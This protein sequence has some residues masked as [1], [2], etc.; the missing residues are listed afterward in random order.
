M[1]D[2]KVEQK[3]KEPQTNMWKD[4]L[5][6][7]MSKKELEDANIFIFGDQLT[8]KK[9]LIRVINKD[10]ISRN[11][12]E[13]KRY[14]NLDDTAPKYGMIDYT[15]LNITKLS[16]KDLESIGKMGVWI[17][18]DSLDKETFQS[19][20]KPEYLVK[21]L[22][23]IVVDLSRPWTI[24][25]SLK[26]W[27][28]F[29]YENFSALI[30]KF[31]FE[32]QQ[33][34]REQIVEKIKLY[35]EAQFDEEG[36]YKKEILSDDQKQIKLDL[37]LKEGVLTTNCGVPIS[38]IVNKSDIVS[39]TS[40]KHFFE[41]NSDFILKHIRQIA[42]SYGASIIYVSGRA[43]INLV[44]LYDYLCHYLFGFHLMH[45]PNLTEKDSFF[46]PAGYDSLT[47]LKNSDT[48]NMLS[49]LYDERI[50]AP[51]EKGYIN[52]EEIFCEETNTFL[53]KIKNEKRS[54]HMP[55][56]SLGNIREPTHRSKAS[57]S[58]PEKEKGNDSPGKF[59]KFMPKKEEKKDE[60]KENKKDESKEEKKEE[61]KEENK[62]EKKQNR[63]ELLSITRQKM[64]DKL[65]LLKKKK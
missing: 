9:S 14:L 60:K 55:S 58:I 13:S 8:G 54:S 37:P 46:I 24:K 2:S 31:P 17:V 16:E 29:I 61:K 65:N 40:E 39:Q 12:E 11:V 33:Q 43:N 62:T 30:L 64:L 1:K 20:I 19:L 36:N 21:C 38:I 15:Y 35:E 41:D 34:M 3:E 42:L 4:I 44:V 18:N 56:G 52:E 48:Q 50:A 27:T 28:N 7:A 59:K 32:K 26:K 45:K 47:A 49:V 63:E 23:L 57:E 53:A 51:K 5:R 6:E 10:V 25:E 22:C